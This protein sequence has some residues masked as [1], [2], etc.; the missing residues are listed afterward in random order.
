M[1]NTMRVYVGTYAKYNN[2]NLTGEWLD[3]EDYAD[4]EDFEAACKELHKDEEDPELMFQDF[5]GFPDGMISESHISEEAF[6]LAQLDDDDL[7]MFKAYRSEV[8]QDG[9]VEEARDSYAGK[10]GKKEDYAEDYYEES[11]CLKEVPDSL[12]YHIDW[13][14]VAREMEMSGTHFVYQGG[15][16]YVFND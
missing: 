10:Y 15:D 4:K 2:G 8:N 5:E 1:A 13:T 12:R 11:G 9:T 16:Y 6:D 14:S 7:E 3:I